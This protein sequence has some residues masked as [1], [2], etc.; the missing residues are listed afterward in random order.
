MPK[1]LELMSGTGSIGR[2]FKAAGWEVVSLDSDPKS[3][4]DI[5][6]DVCTWKPHDG[7]YYDA[8]WCS[9]PC[10]EFSRALTSRPRDL[11]AGLVIADRCLDLIA[12]LKPAVW[13][14]ENPG[15]GYLPKQPRYAE[16]PCKYVTYCTYG[17]K[18]KKLT[19]IATNAIWDPRPCCCKATPCMF[20]ENG[21]H[22][23]CA[24]R[25]PTRCK[26]GLRGSYCS[27]QELYSMP[28]KL[29][30]EIAAAATLSLLYQK[31]KTA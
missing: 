31:S 9:P 21:H 12:Q 25:G 3:G 1:L 28:P 5:I 18:Y 29:C 4:A 6:A 7:A 27:Q 15:T 26:S 20:L 2:A 22:P 23:E 17:F 16:L 10:T 30:A 13:Y 8:I 11:E 24:Q 19:W 14:M